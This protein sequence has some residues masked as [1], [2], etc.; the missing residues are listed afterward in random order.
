M[1]MQVDS[2]D[3]GILATS[4][5]LRESG[6]FE[7]DT[8]EEYAKR[9]GSLASRAET[10]SGSGPVTGDVTGNVTG[11]SN[12]D[13]TGSAGPVTSSD[14][15]RLRYRHVLVLVLVL[16]LTLIRDP[17]QTRVRAKAR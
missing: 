5:L 16:V 6:P 17:D 2:N 14:E 8:P 13:V 11:Y 10:R 9:A 15:T 7:V 3:V 4:G 1:G 12:H